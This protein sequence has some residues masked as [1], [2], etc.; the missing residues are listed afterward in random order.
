[1]RVF[2]FSVHTDCFTSSLILARSRGGV[3]SSLLNLLGAMRKSSVEKAS[4]TSREAY[5]ESIRS[6]SSSN[7][8]SRRSRSTVDLSE[9]PGER[10]Q[11]RA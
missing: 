1:M 3:T 5:S 9:V 2:D 4:K 6:S 10:I 8:G 11:L 7:G